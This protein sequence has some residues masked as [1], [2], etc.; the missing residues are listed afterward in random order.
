M[1]RTLVAPAVL[2][3]LSVL[4]MALALDECSRGHAEAASRPT[5]PQV[6][7]LLAKMTAG[8]EDRADD[9]ARPGGPEGR[10]GR[11]E[12]RRRLGALRRQLRPPDQLLRGLARALRAP[13]GPHAQ[14]AAQD[15]DPL[16]RRRGARPQQRGGGRDLPPQRGPRAPPATPPSWRRSRASPRRRSGPPASTGPS[17]PAW[18][19]PATSAGAA[20][21]RASPRTRSSWPSSGA[22]PPAACRATASSDPLGVLACA[23]HFVG[24]GGTTYGT[25]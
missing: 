15:P 24:D 21:T 10:G 25:A 8:R 2:T 11:R 1:R 3:V 18:R 7:A 20:P 9:A 14:D 23:K 12:P 17:R 19:W 16:R 13:A 5:T 6:N 4:A 22:R